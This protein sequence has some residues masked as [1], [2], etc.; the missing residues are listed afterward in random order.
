MRLSAPKKIV[1]IIS[2]LL[3]IL[4]VVAG[5]AHLVV[6]PYVTAYAYWVMGAAWLL[7][8]LATYLKGL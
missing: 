6:I 5:P 1:W 7:L 4:S 3:A 8:C 2:L